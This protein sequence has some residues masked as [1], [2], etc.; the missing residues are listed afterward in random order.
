MK[1]S[2]GRIVLV[3]LADAF[4]SRAGEIG[5]ER[6]R[7]AIVTR[8]WSETCINIHVFYDPGDQELRVEDRTSVT[9]GEHVGGWRWPPRVA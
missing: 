9:E 4:D 6:L 1:P 5:A 8:V 3:R 7:P 2:V